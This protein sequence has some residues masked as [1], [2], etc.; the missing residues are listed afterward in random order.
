MIENL[1]FA[2]PSL[3]DPK[4]AR[5][6]RQVQLSRDSRADLLFEVGNETILVE[7]KRDRIT[8]AAVA[9]ME[10]Y[11]RRTGKQTTR[12]RGIL[13]APE[14]TAAALNRIRK[15]AFSIVFKKL[16]SEIPTTIKVCRECRNAYDAR[17]TACPRDQVQAVI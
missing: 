14:I 5:P 2:Y 16:G 3:I 8:P 7:I 6:K 12:L 13:I 4:L 1:L 11:A 15:S 9:Q 10:R 17:L